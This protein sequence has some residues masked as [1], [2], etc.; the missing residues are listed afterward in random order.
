MKKQKEIFLESEADAWID[1]NLE[2]IEASK[3]DLTHPV[4]KIISS[5]VDSGEIKGKMNV[6]EIGC[7]E[8]G[9]L[10]WVA[11]KW[12]ASVYGID[13]SK[14]SVALACEKNVDAMLGTA[15][16]LPFENE[17]FDLVIFGFCLY[18]CDREDLFKISYEVNRV[19]KPRSWLIIHDFFS[20]SPEKTPY[21]HKNGLYSY[22]M[23]YRK[24]FNWH[25]AY[26]CFSH[27]ILGHEK[28][29]FT[30]SQDDWVATSLLRKNVEDE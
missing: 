7:G 4:L 22:K 30:D 25:P 21:H 12:G 10:E 14:K 13:P 1:R 16:D 19:L 29:V 24:L 15:D 9:R 11:K 26:T 5:I 18:L 6:L 28:L 27:E 8:G 20:E 2:T 3:Q 23:D 17:I